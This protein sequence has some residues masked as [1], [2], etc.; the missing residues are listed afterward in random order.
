MKQD[1][2]ESWQH[3]VVKA[4]NVK[5]HPTTG[6][7]RFNLTF[8]MGRPDF[9]KAAAVNCHCGRVAALK[10]K[11]GVYFYACNMAGGDAASKCAFHQR[12]PVAQREADRLRAEDD[13]GRRR[14]AA[15]SAPA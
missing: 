15:A 11:A 7:T 9:A 10:A 5:P 14:A 2:Q 1:S 12:A 4:A 13:E 6:T 3:S 8:R